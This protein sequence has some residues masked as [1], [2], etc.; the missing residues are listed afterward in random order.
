MPLSLKIE[1]NSREHFSVFGF[2]KQPFAVNSRW[3]SGAAE[4]LT[5]DLEELLGTKLRALYQRKKGRDLFDLWHALNGS[6]RAPQADR[7]VEAFLKYMEAG[8][9]PI[10]R[11]LFE[12][13]CSK[14]GEIP[15]SQ[16]TRWLAWPRSK[17]LLRRTIRL[18][19]FS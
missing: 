11:A 2:R 19:R 5:Y 14:N 16:G 13:T 15:N 3:F 6:G 9:H 10:S 4:I 17:I 18:L 7:L 8:G 1:I 12:R